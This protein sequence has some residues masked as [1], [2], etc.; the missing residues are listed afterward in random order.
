MKKEHGF[1]N[2]DAKNVIEPEEFE[3]TTL[4]T[5]AQDASDNTEMPDEDVLLRQ[6]LA[7]LKEEYLR[8]LA[9]SENIKKRCAAEIEKNSK[10]AI[11]SFAKD[12]LGV[13]DN[14]QRA[15]SAAGENT[16]ASCE[17]LFKGVELTQNELNHVFE[18]FGIVP[19]EALDTVFNP[20]YHQVV[21][22]IEDAS[23]PVGT[24][25]AELQKGYMIN[26]RIL[27]EAM[28]VVSKGGK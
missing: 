26:G 16:D 24:I 13:A 20:N 9:E 19:M 25:V 5:D 27:R 28:V 14:L 3:E 23:K 6:E 10:Y 17:S 18:R 11:S 15:L 22:E 12:L 7:K 8:A 21:Q 4:Q 1:K 2:Q